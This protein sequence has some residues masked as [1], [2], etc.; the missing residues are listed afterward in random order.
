LYAFDNVFTAPLHGF[1]NTDDYWRRA[2]AKP[3]L[4]NIRIPALVL[5]AKNDPFIPAW[6]LPTQQE[7]GSWVRLWQPEQGGHVGFPQGAFPTHVQGL[8]A[9][10]VDWLQNPV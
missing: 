6:C 9:A 4:A 10:I 1:K 7:V 2:S 5:N 8:P 3:G